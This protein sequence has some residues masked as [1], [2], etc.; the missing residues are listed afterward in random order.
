MNKASAKIRKESARRNDC[1]S[2]MNVQTKIGVKRSAFRTNDFATVQ[3]AP[4]MAS[5]TEVF[6]S[7]FEFSAA[8]RTAL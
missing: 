7:R 4:V 5:I 2:L 6:I 1:A 3:G 8:R